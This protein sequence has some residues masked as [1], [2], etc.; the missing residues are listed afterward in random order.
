MTTP[1]AS[2]TRRRA[3]GRWSDPETPKS[4]WECIDVEDL[5]EPE[6]TCEMCEEAIIRYV[7]LM[8]HP[9]HAELL[10]VGC[11]CAG[12]LERDPDAA[13]RREAAARSRAGRLLRWMR[14]TWRTSAKGNPYLKAKGHLIVLYQS[15]DGWHFAID[16][17]R[18][19]YGHAELDAVKRAA[20]AGLDWIDSRTA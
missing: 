3:P 13:Q 11:V 5:G 1:L 10:R 9:D 8:E 2:S 12:R 16:G 6:S 14:K 20:L 7:H 18:S 15:L 4:G 17:K 19:R